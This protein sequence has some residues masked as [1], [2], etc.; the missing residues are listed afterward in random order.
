MTP[1][2]RQLQ[3]IVTAHLIR[4]NDWR[5]VAIEKRLDL[6]LTKIHYKFE[7]RYIGAQCWNGCCEG[8]K[9]LDWVWVDKKTDR[10][11]T[12]ARNGIEFTGSVDAVLELLEAHYPTI[13]TN[14]AFHH[15]HWYTTLQT[16]GLM[17][18]AK[19]KRAALSASL[20]LTEYI[21]ASGFEG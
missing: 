18:L 16:D 20:A 12:T 7:R 14:L 6:L 3:Q 21:L 19:S 13:K 17:P 2:R 8:G 9:H 1:I 10:W 5:S 15:D 4:K 11:K